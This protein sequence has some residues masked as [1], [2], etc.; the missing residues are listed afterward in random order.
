MMV[1]LYLNPSTVVWTGTSLPP[2]SGYGQMILAAD[3]NYEADYCKIEFHD[4][5][6]PDN[7][8]NIPLIYA[9]PAWIPSIGLSWNSAI[10]RDSQV[11]EIVSRGGQEFPIPRWQKR[12]YE[13]E[14]GEI[15][16]PELWDDAQEL[17]RVS[18]YGGNVLFIPDMASTRVSNEAIYGRAES[19]SD[20]T[21]VTGVAGLHGWRFR[22]RERL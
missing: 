11:D 12:R 13:I 8:L 2:K 1:T 21:F 16:D 10:G 7:F 4:P 3:Q 17:D 19:V 20:V 5:S 15:F 6:N 18:R 14:L 22:I 9:G